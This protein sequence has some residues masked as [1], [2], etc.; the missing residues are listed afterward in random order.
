M[1]YRIIEYLNNGSRV[2][3]VRCRM[4]G[5]DC[6]HHHFEVKDGA[7][8]GFLGMV[9]GSCILGYTYVDQTFKLVSRH[10]LDCIYY[11]VAT[12]DFI[13]ESPDELVKL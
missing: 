11:D 13:R 10:W 9:C 4:C 8:F 3:Y 6:G 1:S 2:L 7:T 12:L 5:V